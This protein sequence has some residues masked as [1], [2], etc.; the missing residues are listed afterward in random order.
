VRGILAERGEDFVAPAT[1]LE[2]EF[3]ALLARCDLPR[4]SRQ[5]DLGS[6]LA[7]IGRV[8][9]VFRDERVVVETDG[10][11]T[12]TSLLDRQA[13]TARDAALVAAGW[14]VLRFS[15]FD[16]VHDG[17]RTLATPRRALHTA[18]PDFVPIRDRGRY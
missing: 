3:V 11:E 18:R 4:P 17:A 10:K 13:D 8:D 9:F 12:H 2:Q 5:V 16:I 1:E 14:I 6:D 7:W 15:W